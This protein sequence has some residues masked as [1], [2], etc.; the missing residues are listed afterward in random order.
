[1][2]KKPGRPRKKQEVFPDGKEEK[3]KEAKTGNDGNVLTSPIPD[4]ISEPVAPAVNAES[5][6]PEPKRFVETP[7]A[8]DAVR[9]AESRKALLQPL[10]PG[11]KFFETPDGEILIG[12]ADK[13]QIWSRRMNGGHGGFV[14]P[15][16]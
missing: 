1:M 9:I 4:T 12:E 6:K 11:Q 10:S 5:P 3:G 15:M 8:P 13:S 14:N 16:R 2:K 7:D